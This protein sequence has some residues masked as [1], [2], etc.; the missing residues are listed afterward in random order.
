LI[1]KC[2]F[3]HLSITLIIS[4]SI[5][6]YAIVHRHPLCGLYV[7]SLA[8]KNNSSNIHIYNFMQIYSKGGKKK[9]GQNLIFSSPETIGSIK[10]FHSSIRVGLEDDYIFINFG[11]VSPSK[12]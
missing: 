3:D 12:R 1:R 6:C 11:G 7:L 4:I 8:G 5:A 10:S 9:I 2:K